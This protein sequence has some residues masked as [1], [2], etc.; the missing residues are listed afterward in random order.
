MEAMKSIIKNKQIYHIILTL[1]VLFLSMPVSHAGEIVLCYSDTGYKI[2]FKSLEENSPECSS[3][4]K[5]N[6]ISQKQEMCF[7]IDIPISKAADENSTFLSTGTLPLKHHI[8]LKHTTILPN[9]SPHDGL[10]TIVNY[11]R[12]KSTTHESLRT[13]VLLI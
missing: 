13:V 9:P 1:Q 12:L 8:C 6:D 2:D 5:S 7:C 3:C 10:F 4:D 11:L